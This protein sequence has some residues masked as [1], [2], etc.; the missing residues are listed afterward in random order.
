M[1][2]INNLIGS[3][4][5]VIMSAADTGNEALT[6]IFNT[7]PK[8]LKSVP[9]LFGGCQRLK[10]VVIP[11]SVKIISPDL[12]K[13]SRI[14]ELYFDGEV[15]QNLKFLRKKNCTIY[16]RQEYKAWYNQALRGR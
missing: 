9:D 2:V 7:V 12:I 10:S 4:G 11:A 5:P 1:H 8:Y 14:S 13:H 16:C 6:G 15:P 3:V